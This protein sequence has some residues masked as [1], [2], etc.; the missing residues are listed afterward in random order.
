VNDISDP[1]IRAFAPQSQQNR[2]QRVTAVVTGIVDKIEDDGTY[3]LRFFGMNGQNE[4]MH[5]A[6][7]RVATPGAGGKRGLHFFPEPGDE[8]VVAFE[9]GDTNHPIILGGV[10]N[11]DSQ[12]PDQAKQSARNDV[13]TIVTR[14]GSELTFDDTPGSERITLRSHTGSV[15]VLDDAPGQEQIVVS[16][17]QGRHVTL[18]DTP[19]GAITV[20]TPTCE[21]ALAEPGVLTIRATAS[22]T[23]SAPIVTLSGGVVTV[24]SSP[25]SAV[26]EG[27]PFGLHTHA[28][29]TLVTGT[30]GPVVP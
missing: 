16:T 3:R 14:S 1:L 20:G 27:L 22:I 26:V 9:A 30:T 29:G 15:V 4:D 11:R 6:R 12:P 7:A 28:G 17:P 5:S 21:I 25:G 19:P 18:D 10:W 24:G 23:L 8:V 2:D 13:R